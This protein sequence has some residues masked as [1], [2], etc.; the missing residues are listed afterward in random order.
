MTT[1]FSRGACGHECVRASVCACVYLRVSML[2][3]SRELVSHKSMSDIVFG[4]PAL[5]SYMRLLHVCVCV[6]VCVYVHVS[7][8]HLLNRN[9]QSKMHC[10]PFL[11]V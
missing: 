3:S 4:S 9:E 11:F 5:S 7:L 8:S 2:L 10:P 6:C 1:W